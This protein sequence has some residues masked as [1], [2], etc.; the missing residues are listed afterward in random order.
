VVGRVGVREML[1]VVVIAASGLILAGLAAMTDWYGHAASPRAP[2]VEI[3]A[4]GGIA[5]QP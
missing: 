4:P 3:I 2:I 1:V 5:G